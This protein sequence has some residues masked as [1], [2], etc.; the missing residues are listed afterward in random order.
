MV[1]SDGSR[2]ASYLGFRRSLR[3]MLLL[4]TTTNQPSIA[5]KHAFERWNDTV[6]RPN[7]R[8]IGC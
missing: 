1:V 5:P 7:V 4:P 8:L 6:R 2:V 3:G